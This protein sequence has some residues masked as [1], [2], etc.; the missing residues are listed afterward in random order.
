MIRLM[1]DILTIVRFVEFLEDCA[2]GDS[3][4]GDSTYGSNDENEDED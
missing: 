1:R 3:Y 2:G 4:D